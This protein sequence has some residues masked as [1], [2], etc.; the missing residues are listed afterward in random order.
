[1]KE[2]LFLTF[3][4]TLV[5][6][7]CVA[8][9]NLE[10]DGCSY[11]VRD[12]REWQDLGVIIEPGAAEY[13]NSFTLAMNNPS[14][15]IEVKRNT[16]FKFKTILSKVV[17]TKISFIVYNS[18][19]RTI[20][21]LERVITEEKTSYLLLLL[22]LLIILMVISN[23][24]FKKDNKNGAGWAFVVFVAFLMAITP[25]EVT[26]IPLVVAVATFFAIFFVVVCSLMHEA[27]QYYF[28]AAKAFYLLITILIVSFFL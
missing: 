4:A 28:F 23:I 12:Y 6:T 26:V 19:T 13:I 2:K 11:R 17:K 5:A 1:M 24:R 22:F 9:I 14:A 20:N 7:I 16:S 3:L 27:H 15:L 18:K 8:Q 25:L 10:S 21:Y